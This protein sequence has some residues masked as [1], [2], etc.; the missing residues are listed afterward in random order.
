MV[1]RDAVRD[2]LQ[3]HRLAGARRRDDQAALALADWYHHVEHARR[4][5]FGF[6]LERDLRLRIERRQVLEKHLLARPFGRLEVDRF[7]LDQR[8]VAHVLECRELQFFGW[9]GRGGVAVP[10]GGGGWWRRRGWGVRCFRFHPRFASRSISV[11]SW[12]S[13]SPVTAETG[14]TEVTNTDSSSFSARIRSPRA[15][16]SILVAT[17]AEFGD[18]RWIQ[19]QAARSLASP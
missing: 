9:G 19:S 1:V 6:G 10:L 14:S 4:Q 16:L 12:S 17:M 5:V 2:I 7:H 13:P 8:E 15:S 18:A 11:H 3:Q